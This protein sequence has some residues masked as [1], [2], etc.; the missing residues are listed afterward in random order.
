M[1][2]SGHHRSAGSL[3]AVCMLRWSRSNS[4]EQAPDRE[5]QALTGRLSLM[6]RA[7]E[8]AGWGTIRTC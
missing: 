4:R 6:H 2:A 7:G 5:L 1:D 3:I 8:V